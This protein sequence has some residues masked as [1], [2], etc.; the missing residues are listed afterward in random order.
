MYRALH[1]P[2]R[3]SLPLVLA[4]Q[5]STRPDTTWITAIGGASLTFGEAD[6][7]A[8]QA[9]SFLES[10]GVGSGERVAVLLP[11]GLDFVRAWMGLGYLRATA[12]LLNTELR[13]TFLQH[14]VN[15]CG[16]RVAIVDATLVGALAEIGGGLDRLQRIV[17]VGAAPADAGDRFARTSWNA[18]RD[19]PPTARTLPEPH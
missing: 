13:G 4:D 14:Q 19:A 12:V 9:A 3:W 10:L 11:N 8:R 1:D 5:A 2:S 17:I 15:N 7:D 16:A 18:W 6:R